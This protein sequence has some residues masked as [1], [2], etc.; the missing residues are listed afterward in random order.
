MKKH[1]PT[2]LLIVLFFPSCIKQA[3][4]DRQK[5]KVID[6]V[7]KGAWYVKSFLRD[8]SNI[9]GSFN[10]YLFYFKEDGTVQAVRDTLQL[11]GTW[12]GDLSARTI[13]SEFPST[14]DPLKLLNGTW[15]IVDSYYDFIIASNSTTT[16]DYRLDLR[17]K[18]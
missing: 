13:T 6:S 10:G 5:Q 3:I 8:T 4:E 9:T 14:S 15:K 7:T 18:Q 16:G 2:I 17:Q 1:L 12:V 11:N